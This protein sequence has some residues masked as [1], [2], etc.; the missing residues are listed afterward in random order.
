MRDI[1]TH[2]YFDID[3]EIIF[4]VCKNNIRPLRDT[5]ST[6]IAEFAI[7]PKY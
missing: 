1:I 2:H 7:K 5:L 3:A 6:I 4:E